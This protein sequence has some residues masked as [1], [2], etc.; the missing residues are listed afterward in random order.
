MRMVG[1]G[2]D[3]KNVNRVSP[4]YKNYVNLLKSEFIRVKVVSNKM[5]VFFGDRGM[6]IDSLIINYDYF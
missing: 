5:Y 6:F 2:L 3:V 1:N 4:N